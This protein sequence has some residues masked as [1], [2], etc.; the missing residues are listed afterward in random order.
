MLEIVTHL[1][2]LQDLD[3]EIRRVEAE[4]KPLPAMADASRKD[5]ASRAKSLD[6][7]A[8]D[9]RALAARQ[10]SLET[11]LK[12]RE[13]SLA[14]FRSQAAMVRTPKEAEAISH[15]IELAEKDISGMEDKILALIEQQEKQTHALAAGRVRAADAD[16]HANEKIARIDATLAEKD[17]LLTAL[18]E[19][20][21]VAANR[22][23]PDLL[24]NYEWH[25]KTH[26]PTAVARMDRESCLGCGAAIVPSFAMQVVAAKELHNCPNCNRF[27]YAKADR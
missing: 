8:A 21:I 4:R 14:K 27:L 17:A 25:L 24:E 1:L 6:D 15:E 19:E 16:T 20:R 5:I 2:A 13:T 11:D 23:P 10:R 18:R 3:I 9:L 12:A 7:A 22:I 26:G